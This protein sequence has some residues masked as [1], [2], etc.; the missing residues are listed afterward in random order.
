MART[1]RN[2]P[3]K[4]VR[5]NKAGAVSLMSWA[6]HLGLPPTCEF[7]L[8]VVENHEPGHEGQRSIVLTPVEQN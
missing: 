6:T 2:D 4:V 5:L 1:K 3:P 7:E 8:T